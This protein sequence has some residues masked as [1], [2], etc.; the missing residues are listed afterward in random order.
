MIEFAAERFAAAI[1]EIKAM[2]PRQ[3]LAMPAHDFPLDVDYQRY[4]AACTAGALITYTA[5]E[6]GALV[7][8]AIYYVGKNQHHKTIGW[9]TSDAIWLDP[10]A[11]RPRVAD[12]MI[13]FIEKDLTERGASVVDHL[14]RPGHDALARLLERRG[15]AKVAIAYS[16]KLR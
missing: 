2:S 10:P 7:G 14:T 15:Y 4:L 1:D 6:N 9:A 12:R 13:D 3:A 11:R 8:Y 5:R 16:R